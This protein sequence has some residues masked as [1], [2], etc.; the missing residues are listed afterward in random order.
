MAQ[1]IIGLDLGSWSIKAVVLESSLRKSTLTS[2]REL[3]L[4]LDE[5]GR[6]AEDTYAETLAQMMQATGDS[7][8][9][10][11]SVPGDRAMTR[12]VSLPFSDEKKIGSILG[13]QL[14][15]VLP[16]DLD[17]L[18]YDYHITGPD[19][20]GGVKLMCP[21]VERTWLDSRLELLGESKADPRYLG[22]QP[23]TNAYV[24]PHLK[25]D[26]ETIVESDEETSEPALALVDVG[27]Q[28]TTV[29]VV[30]RG[31][32][33]SVRTI[34]R[35]G[36]QLTVALCRGLNLSYADA[37][38]LKHHGIRFDGYLPEGV[39]Q[40]EHGDR[41]RIVAQALE[42]ILREIKTT[43]AAHE[44]RT[45]RPVGSA[46]VFG[47]TAE[48]PGVVDL[49]GRVVDVP[50]GTPKPTGP[51]W[52]GLDGV[53]GAST[54]AVAAVGMALQHTVDNGTHRV[55][56]RRGEMAFASDFKDLQNRLAW[57]ALLAVALLALFFVRKY[58]QIQHLEGQQAT[59]VERLD[60]HTER[61]MEMT[62]DNG[63]DIPAKF[64][65]VEE[66]MLAPVDAEADTVYPEMTA[67]KIFYDLTAAQEDVNRAAKVVEEAAKATEEG[68]PD[69]PEVRA[70]IELKSVNA[71]LKGATVSGV[72]YDIETIEA[73][74]EKLRAHNCFKKVDRQETRKNQYGE[75]KGWMTFTIKIEVKCEKPDAK[76]AEAAG[77]GNGKKGE[78]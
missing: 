13:F 59:L 32:V 19:E 73:F 53:D 16:K 61:V 56:F 20:D 72:A 30:D 38:D 34:R 33:T 76:V 52:D 44:G 54:T 2:F 68:K 24:L 21:A 58:L 69:T 67:F 49:I 43:L 27:H 62:F 4:E 48:L 31:V 22:L 46:I 65:L 29:T 60:T 7:D 40:A 1:R 3:R 35:G 26:S 39:E 51:I 55:N 37:E 23:L 12:E 66:E 42:P 78:E 8:A 41:A 63:D 75:R 14:E 47:G 77:A 15:T 9:V 64:Q 74:A 25:R 57:V 71:E 5:T 70:E 45:G 17:Q 36:H 18:A 10:G 50:V 6:P 11:T 28:T